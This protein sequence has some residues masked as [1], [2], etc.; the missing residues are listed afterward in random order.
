MNKT[1]AFIISDDFAFKAK[2]SGIVEKV[3]RTNGIAL[4]KYDDDTKDAIDLASK[5]GKNANMGFYI[6]QI[7][8]LVYE[9]GERFREGDV[10][11]YNP[12]YF[13]GK[14]KNIDYLP[15]TLTKFAIAP[16]DS[17]YEDSTVICETLG[18]RC[19][20]NINI[21]KAVSLGKNATIHSILE[22]G[23][24]V[25]SG[26]HM[27]EFTDSFEDPVTAEFLKNLAMNI[28]DEGAGV[29]T[30]ET[31]DA[32]NTGKITDIK[33]YYNCPFE[34]LSESLQ[35]L[36]KKYKNKNG[37]RANAIKDV[38][39]GSVHIPP[40]EQIKSNKLGKEE[41]V[42]GGGV[43][44][45]IWVEYEDV[46]GLGDKLTYST[47]L[48]GVVSKVLK[49]SEA[50]VSTYRPEDVVEAILTPTGI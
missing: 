14:G 1:L 3:D 43:I 39:T 38:K 49:E 41:F 45:R 44:I 27:I 42:D 20:A 37:Q 8:K 47:A 34:E 9:E 46:M 26:D 2:K 10:L 15:G 16:I 19:T 6:H 4:L 11:A 25:S 33:V 28:G 17:S 5:L 22:I 24:R 12:S 40:L 30:R 13:S 50:P 32:K 18:D 23:D 48:K 21:E 35:A 29:L 7:F 36:V 31:I